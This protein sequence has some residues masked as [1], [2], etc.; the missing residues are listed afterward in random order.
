MLGFQIFKHA[1][2]MV[3]GNFSQVLRITLGPAAIATAIIVAAFLLLG[4]SFQDLEQAE[5]AAPPE[6]LASF[7]AVSLLMFSVFAGTAAWIAVSWHRFILLEERAKGLLPMFRTDRILAYIGRAMLLFLTAMAIIF[8]ASFVLAGL[9]PL[10]SR[11]QVLV[12]IFFVLMLIFLIVM[13]AFIVVLLRLAITLPAAAVGR[14]IGF[15]EAWRSTKG[16]SVQ[17]LALIFVSFLFQFLVQLAIALFSFIPV[18]GILIT[19]FFAMLFVPMINLSILTTLYGYFI[20]NRE[21]T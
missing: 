4:L 10:A 3:L 14:G 13:L 1:L 16:A 11:P 9:P 17:L 12:P 18:I 5:Q 2:R 7:F 8:T 21:L 6:N 19:L 15:G 20:E